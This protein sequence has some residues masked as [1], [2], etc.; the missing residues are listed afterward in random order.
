M[1]QQF[2]DAVKYLVEANKVRCEEFWDAE[3]AAK[4][5]YVLSEIKRLTEST[6][7]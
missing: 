5:E 6:E 4:T 1:T 2:L 3:E 7:K